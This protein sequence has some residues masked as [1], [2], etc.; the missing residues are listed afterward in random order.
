[1]S[2]S[3]PQP[4]GLDLSLRHHVVRTLTLA[5]PVVVT[6]VGMM[7]MASVDVI[8]LGRAGADALADYVLA[9]ALYEGLIATMAGLLLG[10]P[11]LAAK[12]FGAGEFRTL[13]PIWWRG[14]LYGLLLGT[15]LCGLLQ[16][17]EPLF[18][19]AGQPA[20]MAARGSAVT[21]ML[22][23]A[24]PSLALVIVSSS[25][26]EAINRPSVGTMAVLLANLANLALNI[27]LVFGWGPIPALGAI[28]C[29]LATALNSAFL[30]AGLFLYIRY[31]LRDRA[32]LGVVGQPSGGW[33]AATAVRRIGYAAGLS[34]GME[35]GSFSV[36]TLVVG[37][38][39]PLA[40]AMHGVLFQFIALPFMV[41]FGIAAATQVRVGN[42]WGRGDPR[43]LWLA[44]WIGLAL[45][46]LI[47][48]AAAVLYLL[49]PE[50]L[51]GLF[52]TDASVIA[53]ATPIL[54]W[55][56]LV[57]M[58]DGGQTVMN[59]ACRGRGDTWVPTSFHLVSYWVIMIPLAVWL[60]FPVGQ[61]LA[62]IYQ[63]IALASMASLMA[64]AL[65]FTVIAR[66]P[67]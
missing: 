9:T 24:L 46:S 66:R 58:F 19:W 57:L 50:S 18:L 26:L 62:G 3:T 65:R 52:T 61:G 33:A 64:M 39:G 60:T 53:G 17:T 4:T 44:S 47:T 16:F 8:V 23:C 55:T 38:L 54:G 34:Y 36:I 12:A 32:A 28:G 40:L 14:L 48:G 7:T 37:L 59:H 13:G 29:A 6:R 45:A 1:M 5:A 21:G 43:G 11:V 51:V 41:A 63:A 42:A 49:I 20:D 67:L 35:A 10:V 30:A 25:F 56:A 31:G 22:A 15:G 27:P 2:H